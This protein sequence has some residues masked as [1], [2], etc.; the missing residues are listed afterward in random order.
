MLILCA[1]NLKKKL[2]TF[3]VMISDYWACCIH[4]ISNCPHENNIHAKSHRSTCEICILCL[5]VC[6]IA[7]LRLCVP[8]RARACVCVCVDIELCA[9]GRNPFCTLILQSSFQKRGFWKTVE[10]CVLC[11]EALDSG[12]KRVVPTIGEETPS[13]EQAKSVAIQLLCQRV[14]RHTKNAV[15]ISQISTTSKVTWE[16]YKMLNLKQVLHR[17]GA[18]KINALTLPDVVFL[19]QWS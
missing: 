6:L 3:L 7:S 19:W 16:E 9:V 1:R 18:H 17:A 5:F 11:G 8:A 12:G 14:R 2:R 4:R 10:L 15:A 13:T